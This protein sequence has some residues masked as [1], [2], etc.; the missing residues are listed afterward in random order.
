ML[1]IAY[2]EYQ[3]IAKKREGMIELAICRSPTAW[4]LPFLLIR[5][6]RG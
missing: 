3:A 2:N 5:E 1:R 6:I 4:K